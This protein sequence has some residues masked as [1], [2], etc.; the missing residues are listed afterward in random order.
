MNYFSRVSSKAQVVIPKDI[1]D[2]V[3]IGEGDLLMFYVDDSVVNPSE[4]II[5]KICIER[6]IQNENP[7]KES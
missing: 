3:G 7:N 1:R 4:I 6:N 5:R 2:C